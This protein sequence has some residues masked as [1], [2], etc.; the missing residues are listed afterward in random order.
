MR[1]SHARPKMSGREENARGY[2]K[3][4]YEAMK[5]IVCLLLTTTMIMCLFSGCALEEDQEEVTYGI[6]A[7]SVD[8]IVDDEFYIKHGDEFYAIPYGDENFGDNYSGENL[9]YD[10]PE[11]DSSSPADY[12]HRNVFYTKDTTEKNIPTM[13]KGDELVYKSST[14][15]EE[16]FAWER[17]ADGGYTVGIR[18]MY[19]S[20]HDKVMFTNYITSLAE[21]EADLIEAIPVTDSTSSTNGDGT[22]SLKT[23]VLDAV[24]GVKVTPQS[25]TSGEFLK[26]LNTVKDLTLDIYDGTNL[27]RM[28]LKA[29]H[30]VFYGLECYWTTGMQYSNDNYAVIQMGDFFKSGY[31]K[32]NGSGMFRYVDKPYA[33]DMDLNSITFNE[34]FFAMVQDDFSGEYYLDFLLNEDSTR[35]LYDEAEIAA[36]KERRRIEK[37]RLQATPAPNQAVYDE[38]GNLITPSP[39]TGGGKESKEESQE[40]EPTSTTENNG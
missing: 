13:Y 35:Y 39:D 15:V 12:P 26:G 14:S 2:E 4:D 40:S 34:P 31:Y 22:D 29:N 21:D 1:L 17:F 33:N 11:F 9:D 16:N 27:L 10:I 3:G 24:D 19:I 8:E 7:Y 36:E 32:C 18:N 6:V 37:E 20:E 5:R 30:R 38:E 25:L 23:F 28:G